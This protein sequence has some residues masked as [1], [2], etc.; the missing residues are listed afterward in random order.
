[1]LPARPHRSLTAALALLFVLAAPTAALA[2]RAPLDA[3]AGV[4]LSAGVV[5]LTVAPDIDARSGILVTS[6]GRVLW[7]RLPDTQRAMASTTKLMT[8][9]LVLRKG[10]LDEVATVS[11]AA[12][13]VEDGA[14][15]VASETVA[16]SSS[17]PFRSTS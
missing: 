9:L 6:E 13:R 12:S 17:L 14:G 2:Q 10:R 7:S 1:M 8:A 11:R 3:I 15:L 5:T 16:T 4:P